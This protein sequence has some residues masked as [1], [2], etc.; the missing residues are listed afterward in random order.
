[1]QQ[2]KMHVS[3]PVMNVSAMPTAALSGYISLTWP[4]LLFT[5]RK[6]RVTV[7]RSDNIVICWRCSNYA[8]PSTL[9]PAEHIIFVYQ[10]STSLG[11]CPRYRSIDN[12]DSMKIV[13]FFGTKEYSKVEAFRIFLEPLLSLRNFLELGQNVW[14][15][16]FLLTSTPFWIIFKSVDSND[17]ET[18]NV[19]FSM[20]RTAEYRAFLTNIFIIIKTH[21]SVFHSNVGFI[22][23]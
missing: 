16:L 13:I 3:A 4:H 21:F 10:N 23:N 14:I 12:N 18:F 6:S 15:F 9:F 11:S 20:S 22:F 8:P 5:P 19:D 2:T 17:V 7:W 1:M